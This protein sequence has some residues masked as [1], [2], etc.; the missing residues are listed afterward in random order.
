M[1]F[2]ASL[3]ISMQL[4]V[5]GSLLTQSPAYANPSLPTVATICHMPGTVGQKELTIPRVALNN[6]L[7]HGDW[8]GSCEKRP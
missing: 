3:F 2:F 1:N 5:I 8:E 6:H 4:L 7:N